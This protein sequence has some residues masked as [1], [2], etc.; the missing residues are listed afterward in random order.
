M[1]TCSQPIEPCLCLRAWVMIKMRLKLKE[2]SRKLIPET[3]HIRMIMIMILMIMI[4]RCHS[5]QSY[6]QT[7]KGRLCIALVNSEHRMIK[8]Y[9]IKAHWNKYV[10]SE[11]VE[12]LD[13]CQCCGLQEE[14]CFIYV[15][16]TSWEGAVTEYCPFRDC[17]SGLRRPELTSIRVCRVECNHYQVDE[18][19]RTSIM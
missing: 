17:C 10:T 3:V 13:D 4:K 9:A 8:S 5:A 2:C 1:N 15:G 6:I 16:T 18:I 14:D 19:R 7:E 11:L 12:M